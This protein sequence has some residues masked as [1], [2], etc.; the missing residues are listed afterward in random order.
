MENR[1]IAHIEKW[2]FYFMGGFALF[3]CISIAV[4]NVFL[5]LSLVAFLMRLYYKH[6]DIWSR[7]NVERYIT[8]CLAF[9]MVTVLISAL[10][11]GNIR[12][13]VSLFGDYYGY[14]MLGFYVVLIAVYDKR[15]LTILALLVMISF[16]LNNCS[17]LVAALG[18]DD[19]PGGLVSGIMTAAGILSMGCPVLVFYCL[20]H[21]LW[22]KWKTG[23]M[24]AIA[25]LFIAITAL[26]CN[27]T[28]GAWIAV[29]VTGAVGC[30]MA[31][32][33]SW[34]IFLLGGMSVLLAGAVFT[35]SPE[36]YHRV[37]SIGNV[38]TDSSNVERLYI[39]KSSLQMFE[40]HPLLGVGF[41]QYE[42]SYHEKYILP[43]AKMK[44]LGHAHSNVMQ[45][46]G[47]SGL[48]GCTALVIFWACLLSYG[49]RGWRRK[50]NPAYA[51]LF[52]IV[53]GMILQGLTEYNMGNSV[54][55]KLYW[56]I[57][58]ICLQWIRLSKEEIES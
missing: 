29:G 26:I 14:R 20:H 47:E 38:S 51:A 4:G 5:S 8:G 1:R 23:R 13:G 43:E 40:D 37:L 36:V 41:S 34:K 31:V 49:Y 45:Y 30:L 16:T 27:E 56:F 3:S 50:R 57:V 17:I 39:W 48:L 54:V 15:R 11:S 7:L 24:Y 28:R 58:A 2:I 44:Y 9:L 6:D 22:E 55:A 10:F 25:M 35:V 52:L 19:R 53:L 18:G 32:R 21:V 46:L 42:K 12:A 33:S